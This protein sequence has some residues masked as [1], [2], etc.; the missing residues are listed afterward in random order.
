MGMLVA[1]LAFFKFI[2]EGMVTLDDSKNK[3]A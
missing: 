1:A 2:P 3:D